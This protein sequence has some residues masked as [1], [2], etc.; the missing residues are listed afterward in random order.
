GAVI[1][2]LGSGAGFLVVSAGYLAAAAALLP[3][4]SPVRARPP[5]TGSLWQSVASFV[6]ALRNDRVLPLLMVLTA[7]AEVLGFAHQALLPSLARD[8]LQAGPEGLGALNAARSAGGIL[9]LVAVSL[10]DAGGGGGAR[11]LAVQITFG[12]G[13]VVLG[14]APY[15]MDF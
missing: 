4:S 9:A 13:L 1:A 7:G 14:L 8:V 10:R 6:A 15:V 3:A 5:A 11:F 12:V 2:H